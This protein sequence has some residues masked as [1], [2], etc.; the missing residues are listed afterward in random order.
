MLRFQQNRNM[1]IN[2]EYISIHIELNAGTSLE[3][4]AWPHQGNLG[5]VYFRFTGR[6]GANTVATKMH[7]ETWNEFTERLDQGWTLSPLIKEL[8]ATLEKALKESHAHSITA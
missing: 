1:I 3:L 2:E 4:E 7:N 5:N 8:I 6:Y